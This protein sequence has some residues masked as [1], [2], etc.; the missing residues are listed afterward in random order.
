MT[1]DLTRKW[2]ISV[3]FTESQEAWEIVFPFAQSL[4][5]TGAVFYE[6][7]V[8]CPTLSHQNY[9]SQVEWRSDREVWHQGRGS[10]LKVTFQSTQ[11]MP[12]IYLSSVLSAALILHPHLFLSLCLPLLL[13]LTSLCLFWLSFAFLLVLFFACLPTLPCS[14]MCWRGNREETV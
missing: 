9:N 14:V 3:Q 10:H 12:P 8:L 13:P 6:R 4:S 2:S 1:F 7:S 5:W 11:Q